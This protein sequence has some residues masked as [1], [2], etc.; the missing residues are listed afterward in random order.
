MH[1]A[2][3]VVDRKLNDL[4]KGRLS[5]RGARRSDFKAALADTLSHEIGARTSGP[6]P[7]LIRAGQHQQRLASYFVPASPNALSMQP[8]L[9]GVRALVVAVEQGIGA[10]ADPAMVRDLFGLSLGEARLAVLIAAGRNPRE[11][12]EELCFGEA[13]ARTVLKRVF[14]KVGVSRQADLAALLARMALRSDK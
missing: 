2:P 8:V 9:T 1:R 4:H 3:P 7:I 10:P 12:A 14:G 11:A 6:K 5:V 13:S